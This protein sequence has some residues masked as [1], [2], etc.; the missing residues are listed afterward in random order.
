[1]LRE[2]LARLLG[3]RSYRAPV[4]R[5]WLLTVGLVVGFLAVVALQL[6]PPDP[7]S[8]LPASFRLAALIDRQQHENQAQRVAV[9]DLRRELETERNEILS[10]RAGL[11]EVNTSLSEAAFLA[12]TSSVQGMGFT[13]SLNDSTLTQAASGNVNDLVIHSQDVQAVVN[14]MWASG[15]EAVSINGERVVAT[16]A[17][18]CVGNTLLLNGTVHSPPYLISGIGANRTQYQDDPLVNQ[19]ETDAERFTLRY[20]VGREEMLELPGYR[21]ATA[22]RYAQVSG[23]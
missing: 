7:E 1:M 6:T 3:V 11:E 16:S 2:R 15:A 13:V 12:G 8:R 20:S 17:I 5:P 23:A 18:L 9:E 21:G 4:Q 22:P 10:Q 14:G 19:L